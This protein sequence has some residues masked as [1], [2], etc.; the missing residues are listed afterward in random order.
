[1]PWFSPAAK[2]HRPLASTYS[3]YTPA[4]YWYKETPDQ[5]DCRYCHNISKN[6]LGHSAFGKPCVHGLDIHAYVAA[7]KTVVPLNQTTYYIL[8]TTRWCFPTDRCRRD[9]DLFD[10]TRY[11]T[12]A[13]PHAE[14]K[15]ER[16]TGAGGGEN[17]DRHRLMATNYDTRCIGMF[18]MPRTK[19]KKC[20]QIKQTNPSRA[21]TGM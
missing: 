20:R 13:P 4:W 19:K 14:R 8:Y 3:V 6:F 21:C 18:H 1:M 7:S 5:K 12:V 16:E 15:R 2:G 11:Y 9:L 10:D 17:V